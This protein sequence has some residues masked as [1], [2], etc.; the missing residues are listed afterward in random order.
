[1]HRI[2][3]TASYLCSVL[4]RRWGALEFPTPISAFPP[5]ALLTQLHTLYNMYY[6]PTPKAS[7][8]PSTCLKND[9]SV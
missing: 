7:G 9:D 4:Y 3:Y 5:Q 6:F 8:P 1:M 2:Y